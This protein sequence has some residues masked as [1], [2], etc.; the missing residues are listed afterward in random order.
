MKKILLIPLSIILL[1][2]WSHYAISVEPYNIYTTSVGPIV[3]ETKTIE[4]P[5]IQKTFSIVKT[6]T[7]KEQIISKVSE[8]L[9][10]SNVRLIAFY[11]KNDDPKLSEALVELNENIF[12]IVKF[13]KDQPIE[14]F[15]LKPVLIK[16][17]SESEEVI[18]EIESLL[19]KNNFTCTKIVKGLKYSVYKLEPE[20]NY[21][22]LATTYAIIVDQPI[23]GYN[24]LNQVIWH[25]S[26]KSTTYILDW[27]E[28]I[29][30]TDQSYYWVAS[31]AQV[32]WRCENWNHYAEIK[33]NGLHSYTWAEGDFVYHLPS[34]VGEIVLQR[35]HG[36]AWINV[37]YNG[38]VE[39]DAGAS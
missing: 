25:L 8:Y 33:A 16:E 36:W 38:N 14:T 21:V 32:T 30:V 28:V 7:S 24:A 1:I 5:S 31:W 15:L 19:P 37:W 9:G 11:Y 13:V 4:L 2:L 12:A 26:A 29:S 22:P 17:K 27:T 10:Y 35:I 3:V 18:M 39:S 34:P 20:K 23:E 6:D